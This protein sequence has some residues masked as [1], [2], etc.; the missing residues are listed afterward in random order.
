MSSKSTMR[1]L[2][3]LVIAA[4]TACTDG[5]LARRSIEMLSTTPPPTNSLALVISYQFEGTPTD[6]YQMLMKGNSLFLTGE[7][8]RFSRWDIG[9]DPARPFLTFAASRNLGTFS[10]MGFWRSDWYG[11][12]AMAIYGQTAILSGSVGSSVISLADTNNPREVQRYPAIVPGA[13]TVPS[14]PAY[15]YTALVPHPSKPILYGFRQQDYMYLIDV[16]QGTLKLSQRYA[17]GNAGE[18]VCCAMA[19]TILQNKV[20]VAFRDRLLVYNITDSGVLDTP[21]EA[22][23]LNAVNVVSSANRL[24]VQHD[25]TTAPSSGSSYPAGIYVFDANGTSIGFFAAGNPRKFAVTSDDRYLYANMDGNSVKI[26]R[27][28]WTN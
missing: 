13:V 5:R 23:Q 26:F 27:I 12:G 6:S 10:P 17:Y 22:T 1:V 24:Y 19:A 20:Y 25:P 8:F 7:P 11:S 15:V 28:Q 18:T 3:I 16:S 2:S 9:S 4:L 21:Q 14:D